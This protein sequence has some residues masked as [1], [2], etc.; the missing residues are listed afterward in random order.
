MRFESADMGGVKLVKTFT[1]KRGSYAIDAARCG[2]HRHYRCEPSAVHA[3]G[4]RH[5]PEHE[6]TFYSTFTGPALYTEAKKYHKVEFKTSRTT[7]LK[8]TS[9]PPMAMWPW[10]STTSPAHGC[11]LTVSSATTSCAR[12]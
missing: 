7:R 4:A 12:W 11:W 5:K 6:S 2:Q 8:S 10:C 9:P 3:A 1:L